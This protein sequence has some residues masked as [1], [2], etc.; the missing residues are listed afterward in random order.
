[1]T[2]FYTIILKKY[3]RF[4]DIHAKFYLHTHCNT[5]YQL[6]LHYNLTNIQCLKVYK[7]KYLFYL[8][9]LILNNQWNIDFFLHN[10]L[11]SMWGLKV[12]K[13]IYLFYICTLIQNI[14]SN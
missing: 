4:N 13:Q 14:L 3:T 10:N 1:M 8:C 9:T 2:L 11:K 12:Y 5:K 6:F 7:Q